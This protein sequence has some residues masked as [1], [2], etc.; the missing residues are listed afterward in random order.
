LQR[1]KGFAGALTATAI[2]AAAAPAGAATFMLTNPGTM[3]EVPLVVIFTATS[4]ES[5]LI[6][7]GYQSYDIETLSNNM[8]TLLGG[9]PN[10]LGSKWQHRFATTGSNAFTFSDGTS[11][12]ALG[13]AGAMQTKQSNM[14]TYYQM[15]ATTPGDTYTYTFNFSNNTGGLGAMPSAVDVAF[16]AVPEASTWAML[17][18]G[19]AGLGLASYR[20]RRAA[21]SI[22]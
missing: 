2:Y 7:Q 17:L 5:I 15:F 21:G 20:V 19:F 11:V 3:S 10:L 9:G 22:A 13:F 4:T 6:D 14:D 8:V 12:F 1:H 18:L 16:T